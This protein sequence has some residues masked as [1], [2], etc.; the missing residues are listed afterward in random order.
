V[1]DRFSRGGTLKTLKYLQ[2]LDSF[3]VA[4]KSYTEQTEAA[5]DPPKEA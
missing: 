2:R 1:L 4:W 3:G 5:K